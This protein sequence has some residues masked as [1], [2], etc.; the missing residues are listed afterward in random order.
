MQAIEKRAGVV[1][2]RSRRRGGFTLMEG[3]IASVVLAILVLGV[4]STLG[5]SYQ[6]AVIVKNNAAGI[7][8]GRQLADEITSKP[9]ADPSSGSTT[10]GPGTGMTT[11]GTFTHVTNYSGYS[12]TSTSM[13]LLAGGTLDV[14]GSDL[15]SRSVNVVVGAK[16]SID[17]A[18]PT[19]DFAIVTVTVTGPDGQR[20]A[21]PK[22]VAKY[23]IQR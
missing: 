14:T 17:T 2:R 3:L 8:L 16:P 21:I 9:L 5:T 20:V 19:T 12:D 18:S 23:A 11:R 7:M 1:A 4:C 15:Y 22:F 6:Q 10:L 13:P